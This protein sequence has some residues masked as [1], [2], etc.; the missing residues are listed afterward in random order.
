M[1]GEGVHLIRNAG[2][3]GWWSEEMVDGRGA[4][5]HSMHR[6]VRAVVVMGVRSV[7]QERADEEH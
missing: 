3:W 4:T 5:L 2:L 1:D 6:T 7:Y